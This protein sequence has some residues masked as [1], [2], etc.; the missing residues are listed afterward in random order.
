MNEY[1]G[2]FPSAAS[3]TK[4]SVVTNLVAKCGQSRGA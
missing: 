2:R 1:V 4:W 3:A